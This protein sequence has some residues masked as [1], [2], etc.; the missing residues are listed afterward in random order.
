MS[1]SE[2][3]TV[4]FLTT[5]QLQVVTDY[6]NEQIEYGRQVIHTAAYTQGYKVGYDDGYDDAANFIADD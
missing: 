4:D 6:V 5:E 1:A 3:I 2:S